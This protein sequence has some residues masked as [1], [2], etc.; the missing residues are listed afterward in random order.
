M[1]Q[2]TYPGSYQMLL[3]LEDEIFR[4]VMP[5]FLRA[6]FIRLAG[7][8]VRGWCAMAQLLISVVQRVRSNQNRR[9]RKSVR[10]T[11]EHMDDLLVFSGQE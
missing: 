9:V 10:R 2:P 5:D 3:S 8:R 1:T 7:L 11:D 4:S 6:N